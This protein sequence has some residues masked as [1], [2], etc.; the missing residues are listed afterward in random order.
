MPI[1]NQLRYDLNQ[2]VDEAGVLPDEQLERYRID[3]LVPKAV[4][5]PASIHEIQEVLIYAGERKLSIIPAGNGTKLGVGN[6][7]EKVELVLSMTR[8]KGMLEY[9]PADLTVTVQAGIR[10]ADFQGKLAENGQWLPI[11][12]PYTDRA[13]L[14]GIIAANSSGPSRLRYGTAR[15][16]VIGLQVIQ[17]NGTVV[18]SGGKVVKNVAGYDLNKL[19][20]GSFGT[21][22]I[23]TELTFKLF[24][25]PE[26]EC[27]VLL[28]FREIGQGASVALEFTR[29]QLLPTFLNLFN[30]MPFSEI[31]DPC[32]V[33]GLDGHPET[34]AWQVE[35]VQS[36]AKQNGAVGVE[37]CTGERQR[38]LRV[39]M[40]T[41]PEGARTLQSTI[42]K[43]NLR[44]TDVEGFINA[45][46]VIGNDLHG[47]VHT[48][49]L[50]GNGIV[51]VAFS[52]LPE[53][54]E[55]ASAI[56]RLRDD[57]IRVGGNLIVEAAPTALKRQI[58]V[59]GPVGNS[60]GLMKGI[61]A[62]LD[63]IGLLNPGRFVAGI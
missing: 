37:V 49:G 45:A 63:S 47:T 20:I 10:L 17:S 57:A 25:L 60:L 12:P 61:K 2:I 8:L 34:V 59:W 41:F 1:S 62:K 39:L 24:P 32:L 42:C 54:A 29:S 15:D 11:D 5:C 19:Y 52:E 26:T 35:Q 31:A 21:L 55:L 16:L 48:M 50:M 51:Y 36:L 23:I 6:P 33:I 46:L 43:A 22:G 27:T 58:D 18:K 38:A 3:D 30:A 9:E 28:T 14:G 4:V 7:P 56:A 13:T 40:R 53:R 44:L